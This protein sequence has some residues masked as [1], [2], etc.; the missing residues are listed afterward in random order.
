[1]NHLKKYENYEMS[2]NKGMPI[3]SKEEIEAYENMENAIINYIKITRAENK[4]ILGIW[5]VLDDN[6]T[7]QDWTTF[8]KL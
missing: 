2:D 6:F 5:S 1:M 3:S 7:E 8:K 4:Y